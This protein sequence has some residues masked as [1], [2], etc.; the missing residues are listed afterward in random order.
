MTTAAW[1]LLGLLLLLVATKLV[2]A[3]RPDVATVARWHNVAWAAALGLLATGWVRYAPASPMAWLTLFCGILAFNVG[4]LLALNSRGD[5]V[6]ARSQRVD[7]VTRHQLLSLT[8]VYA[9]GFA[10]YLAVI[11]SNYGLDTL[12]MNPGAIR[13]QTS[14]TSYI[15][16]VPFWARLSLFLGPLLLVLYAWTPAVSRP[17]PRSVRWGGAIVMA[18]SQIALL[19]RTNL[20]LGALWLIA[21]VL[22]SS[23]PT[24]D[25]R[26][27]RRRVVQVGAM[28][29]V[30]FVVFQGLAGALNKTSSQAAEG[31]LVSPILVETSTVAPYIYATSG[32]IAFLHLTDSRN[33]ESIP[34]QRVT[35]MRIGD[36]NPQ[37]W[38]RASGTLFL[39]AVPVAEPHEPIAPF[40]DIGV[41]TNVFTWYEP[42]YRDFRLAGVTLGSLA[43]GALMAS[44]Y[45]R[46]LTSRRAFWLATAFMAAMF[47]APFV[48]IYTQ[49]IFV[50]G[51]VMVSALTLRIIP[52]RRPSVASPSRDLA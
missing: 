45:G 10:A 31:G 33:H 46:R 42:L 11:A 44:L 22:C 26:A 16:L 5:E 32:T 23:N 1:S 43:L 25:P 7:L 37:T 28:G 30:L 48:A 20:F 9:V 27:G 36:W 2:T 6:E 24:R 50:V 21:V 14:A 41:L 39:K 3:V 29:L 15:G 40:I 47:H 12:L 13:A 34:P 18:L 52:T 19:Q 4:V 38:G 49:T 8:L 17:L 51:L 35:S